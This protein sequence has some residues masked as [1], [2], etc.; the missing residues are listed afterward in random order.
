MGPLC[1]FGPTRQ[2]MLTTLAG[3]QNNLVPWSTIPDDEF[4]HHVRV[5]DSDR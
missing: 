5:C 1:R 4:L 2:Q 3:A